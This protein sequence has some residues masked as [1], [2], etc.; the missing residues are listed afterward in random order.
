MKKLAIFILISL[1]LILVYLT[2]FI[3]NET[4]YAIVTQFGKPINII[5]EAGLYFKLPG[6]I[7]KINRLD[8]RTDILI[9][10][11]LQLLLGDKNPI[12]L[13]C[14][15][16]WRIDN[17]LLF[18]QSIINKEVAQQKINDMINSHL[19][20]TLC[21]YTIENII[22]T[23][24]E[25]VKLQEIEDK[26]VTHSNEKT[27]KR[28]GIEIISVGIRGINYPSIVAQSVY[29][30]MRAEREKE[31]KRH[32]A[33]GEEAAAKIRA[34]TD[35]EVAQIQSEAYKQSEII[36]GKGDKEAIKIYADAYGQDPEFFTFLKS[37]ETLKEIL[38]DKATVILST[39]SELLKYLD[40]Q[41]NENK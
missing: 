34:E 22:N 8:K 20:S 21:D 14:Y 16:C 30:R 26:I 28:Y 41:P 35:K 24:P 29:D 18:F 27:M 38:Q 19:G 36:K 5:K 9:T 6:F 40:Y 33:E 10:Q 25:Q 11:P 31:A 1:V 39:D 4:E 13:T 23:D 32:R 37:H 17:P 3:V 7:Q 15:A 12:I 2:A